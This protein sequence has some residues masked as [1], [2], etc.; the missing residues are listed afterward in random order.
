MY[1]FYVLYLHV[2]L[3]RQWLKC[4]IILLNLF[5]QHYWGI[6]RQKPWIFPNEMIRLTFVANKKHF[7]WPWFYFFNCLCVGRVWRRQ[8]T[9]R[10]SLIMSRLGSKSPCCTTWICSCTVW[11]RT[12]AISISIAVWFALDPVFILILVLFFLFFHFYKGI[13]PP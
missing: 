9:K 5:R 13:L 10:N 7:F 8:Q 11:L 6:Q 12:L 2:D 3:E 1:E 4:E